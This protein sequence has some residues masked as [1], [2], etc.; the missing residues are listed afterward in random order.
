MINPQT[1]ATRIHSNPGIVGVLLFVKSG[2]SVRVASVVRRVI[3]FGVHRPTLEA[4]VA[5]V[6]PVLW[7]WQTG[8]LP[9]QF[10]QFTFC[11][12]YGNAPEEVVI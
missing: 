11:K 1:P 5:L 10:D 7:V 3:D 2:L 6:W 8:V 12:R 4:L 9:T